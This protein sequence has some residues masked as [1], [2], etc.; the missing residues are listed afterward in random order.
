[1]LGGKWRLLLLRGLAGGPRRY[2]QLRQQLPDIS[3]KVLAQELKNLADAGLLTRR[4]YGEVPPRV[5]YALTARGKLALPVLEAL[6]HFGL[7]YGAPAEAP[8][9]LTNTDHAK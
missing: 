2:G 9:D 7:A 3:E 4:N 8:T 1:M 5:D 6:L